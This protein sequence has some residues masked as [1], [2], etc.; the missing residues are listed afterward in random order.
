[1]LLPGIYLAMLLAF[2]ETTQPKFEAQTIDGNIAIGY[3]LAL[4]DVDGDG[5]PD[6]LLA[7][8]K[9]FVW[10]RNGD[11]KKF[12]MAENLTEHDNVCIA[13]RDINGDGKVEVAVGAQWNPSE[14]SNAE[15]SGAVYYLARPDDPTQLWKPFKL[16]HEPTIHRMQWYKSPTGKAYLIVA[17]LHGIGNK[18][19]E[20]TGVN[21]LI[22]EY[23]QDINSEW[24]LHKIASNMHLTH[25]FEIAESGDKNKSGFYLA[26]KEGVKFIYEDSF[27][28]LNSIIDQLP[29]MDSAAGEIRTGKSLSKENFI[30]TIEPMHGQKLV[31]YPQGGKSKRIVV[32]DNLREGHALAT[33]DFLGK[34]SDQVIAG[35]R[36]P[37]KDSLV[38]IKLYVEKI[39]SGSGW[40]SYWID[41]NEMACEDIKV[42]DLD[43]DG[44][45]DIIASGRSTHNLKIYWN[46]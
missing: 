13:A 35:W 32:D 2:I 8:K 40:D 23:P 20:G 28:G 37:D 3:G 16:Y 15:Q 36:V 14:T 26:G 34:G 38:G 21:I 9:Q 10:Y 45:P 31:I 17:P 42:M 19:G 11:W 12:V 6:I 29:G 18:N 1:M 24:P 39:A 7:D 4:G 27:T 30:A 25:N 46:R 33:A 5:K 43:Q 22:F 44:K 41:K